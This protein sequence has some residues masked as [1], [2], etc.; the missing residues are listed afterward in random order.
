MGGVFVVI[1]MLVI[2]FSGKIVPVGALVILV[3]W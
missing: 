3:G 2:S 1:S